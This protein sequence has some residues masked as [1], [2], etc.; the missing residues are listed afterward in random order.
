MQITYVC[1]SQSPI[2]MANPKTAIIL[3]TRRVKKDG[4]FPVKVRVTF[5]RKQR[6]Y[7]T[8]YNLT[9]A[10]FKKVMFAERRTGDEKELKNGAI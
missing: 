7:P 9:E 5:E 2:N 10:E 1:L 6:Y 3:D 4:A 8:P